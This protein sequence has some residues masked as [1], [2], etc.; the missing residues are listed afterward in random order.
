MSAP[1][2]LTAEIVAEMTALGATFEIEQTPA[3]DVWVWFARPA[4]QRDA[5]AA[6]WNGV[7]KP[8]GLRSAMTEAIR[9]RQI[10]GAL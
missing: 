1:H 8:P 5:V 10:G 3:G 7:E 4:S 9:R 6:F 2:Q